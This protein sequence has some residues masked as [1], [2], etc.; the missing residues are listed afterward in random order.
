[1]SVRAAFAAHTR[2]GWRALSP[3]V[4]DPGGMDGMLMPGAPATF[5]VWETPGGVMN[6]L[7][8]LPAEPDEEFAVPVCRATVLRGSPIFGEV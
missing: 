6:G 1:M 7:P 8:A 2:G 5:A 4:T 3:S